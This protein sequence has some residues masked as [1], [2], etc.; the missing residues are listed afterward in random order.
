[1]SARISWTTQLE[2]SERGPKPQLNNA[3]RVL[4]LDP[5]WGPDRLWYDEFLGRVQ[6][7]NSPTREWADED[8]T[9]LTAYMQDTCGLAGIK[10]SLVASAVRYIAKQQRVKHCVRDWLTA[11]VW[12][13]EPRIDQ[14]FQRYWGALVT[15]EQPQDYLC[16]V[17]R[18]FMLSLCARVRVPGCKADCMVV[19]EG[20]QGVGKERSLTALAGPWYMVSQYPVTSIDFF[21]AIPGKWIIEIGEMDS[22][23]RGEK[24]RIKLAVSTPVDRYRT[25]NAR[26]ARDVPRQ[27]QFVGTTNKDDW[28]NDDT[29]LRRFWP[30]RCG[31]IDVDAIDRDRAQLFAEAWHRLHEPG[32]SWWQMPT[33]TLH[34]QADRQV[35]DVWTS[36]VLSAIQFQSDVA[37]AD[38]LRDTLKI[39]DA[40]MTRLHQLRVGSILS[41]A[42][43]T[44]RPARREGRLQ[45]RWF[46][47]DSPPEEGEQ[48]N[49]G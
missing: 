41:L 8:D 48:G 47:P 28:G 6:L 20:R 18:N 44:K 12:D 45:K 26:H 23:N 10:E 11:Q 4:Q 37:I 1:M 22:F 13:D 38:I 19:L 24:E 46:S 29:G 34:V 36:T 14:L 39:R 31:R 5:L 40:D 30:V 7:A 35:D 33:S 16:A 21:R 43:W 32:A 3:I 42:G 17:S 49:E 15:A 2:C 25:P 27:C 9:R